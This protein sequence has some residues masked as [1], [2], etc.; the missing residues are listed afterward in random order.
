VPVNKSLI[1]WVGEHWRTI[2]AFIKDTYSTDKYADI[3]LRSHLE[4]LANVLLAIN[5]DKFKEVTRPFFNTGISIQRIINKENEDSVL[6]KKDVANFVPYEDLVRE[7]DKLFELWHHD[8]KN[9]KLNMFHLILAVNTYIPPLRLNFVDM[10]IYPPRI[11][12]GRVLLKMRQITYLHLVN[13]L[14]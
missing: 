7:R 11:V 5:K 6:S 8:P 14:L 12:N 13:G 4:G 2:F 1:N 3:T 10:E 9:L